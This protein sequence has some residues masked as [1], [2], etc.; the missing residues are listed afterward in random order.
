MSGSEKAV[1]VALGASIGVGIYQLVSSPWGEEKKNGDHA[2]ENGIPS[3]GDSI[4]SFLMA[5]CPVKFD[6][7]ENNQEV[8]NLPRDQSSS[9]MANN[10]SNGT[11]IKEDD[12]NKVNFGR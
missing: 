12:V 5:A 8:R 6:N 7:T 1:F 2:V 10:M 11:H 3:F 9:L 4:K